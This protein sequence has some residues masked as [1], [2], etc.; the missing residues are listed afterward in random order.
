MKTILTFISA[1]ICCIGACAQNSKMV[2]TYMNGE[3]LELALSDSPVMTIEGD[4]LSIECAQ[5][6]YRCALKDL[7]EYTFVDKTG[8]LNDVTGDYNLDRHG[9]M[10]F[11]NANGSSLSITMYSLQGSK[12]LEVTDGKDGETRIDLSDIEPGI[13]VLVINGNA[14]KIIR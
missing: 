7:K 11:I 8:G 4:E 13:Y 1:I 9:D 6:S 2:L 14:I 3:I 10:I 12:I 5:S